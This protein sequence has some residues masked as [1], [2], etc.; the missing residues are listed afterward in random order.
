MTLD[1]LATALGQTTLAITPQGMTEIYRNLAVDLLALAQNQRE[2]IWELEKLHEN[3]G[4]DVE[5]RAAWR[6]AELRAQGKSC[7]LVIRAVDRQQ[8][9]PLYT[10]E[11]VECHSDDPQAV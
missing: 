8:G 5:D 9:G 3:S 4:E 10:V 2:R 1:E 7:K 11:C 6:A